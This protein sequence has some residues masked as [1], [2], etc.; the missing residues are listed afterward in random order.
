MTIPGPSKASE[1]YS[2]FFAQCDQEGFPDR[3]YLEWVSK[4][5]AR[6]ARLDSKNPVKTL[7][8]S[9]TGSHLA[10]SRADGTL[11][12]WK[13]KSDRAETYLSVEFELPRNVS[14]TG[15]VE[16]P[17]CG[18]TWHPITGFL[19]ATVNGSSC[20]NVHDVF[21]GALIKNIDTNGDLSFR[22]LSYSP[23]GS[24]LVALA[25]D[26]Q[27]CL[28]DI[29]GDYKQLWTSSSKARSEGPPEPTV[30]ATTFT[31][32][33]DS[34]ML[35]VAFNSGE[36]RV[37]KV[38]ETALEHYTSVSG[39]TG[40]I[41]RLKI[42]S[43]GLFLFAGGSDTICSIWNL[44]NMCCVKIISDFTGPIMDLDISSDNVA[45]ALTSPLHTQIYAMDTSESL[46]SLAPQQNIE[47]PI[48]R[49]YPGRM[50]FVT[51]S[52]NEE[53][54]KYHKLAPTEA[55]N[56]S[57]TVEREKNGRH[58]RNGAGIKTSRRREDDRSWRGSRFPKRSARR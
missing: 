30:T 7:E 42:D 21:T 57:D 5:S 2:K 45:L 6:S 58:D 40:A 12:L 8:F 3:H 1:N 11:N 56:R 37:F 51:I 48:F 17:V 47:I 44:T 23:D 24:L 49:F 43:T 20:I 32:S 22:K 36:I 14:S 54:V 34:S 28:F 4:Q 16:R 29:D 33:Q 50:A 46:H 39:H 15:P 18:M 27:F 26:G 53:V 52:E 10:Y 35:Y 41:N 19:L 9:P 13:L 25:E 38:G 31:W 55:G